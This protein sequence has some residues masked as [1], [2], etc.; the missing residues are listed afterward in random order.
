MT[1]TFS[2]YNATAERFEADHLAIN[3]SNANAAHVLDALG[4]GDDVRAGDLCGTVDGEDFL[5]RV[6]MAD[7]VS[8]EDEG[9]PSHEIARAGN[10]QWIEG[11]RPPGYLQDRLAQL[12]DLAQAATEG[13]YQ[14]TWA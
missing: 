5:G 12:R 6:L 9:V 3:L 11:G 7:A 1:I 14:V 2:A 13:G 10:A 4:F 8:P